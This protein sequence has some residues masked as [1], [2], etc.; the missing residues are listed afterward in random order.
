MPGFRLRLENSYWSKGFFNVGVDFQRFVTM[1]AGPFDV[2]LEDAG[3]AERAC[4]ERA[5]TCPVLHG[6]R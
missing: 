2:Y 1:T 6:C 3:K 5:L 4:R